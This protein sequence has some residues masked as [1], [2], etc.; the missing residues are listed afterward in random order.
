M[1]K[2]GFGCMRLPVNGDGSINMDVLNRMVDAFMEKGFTYFDT[3]YVYHNGNSEKVL[4]DAGQ[5]VS[6]RFVYHYDQ[7]AGFHDPESEAVL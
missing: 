5:T 2:L 7:V 6:E 3:S 4:K 1:K